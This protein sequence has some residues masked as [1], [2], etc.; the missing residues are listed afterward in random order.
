[1]RFW[2]ERDDPHKTLGTR[3]AT[4]GEGQ[5][6]FPDLITDECRPADPS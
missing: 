3:R 6:D 4:D 2:G 1:M 5:R